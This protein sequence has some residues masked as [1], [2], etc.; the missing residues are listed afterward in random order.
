MDKTG[1]R[2]GG[3]D[4]TFSQVGDQ[5]VDANQTGGGEPRKA[6]RIVAQPWDKV[7]KHRSVVAPV[8]SNAN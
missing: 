7:T 2:R 5:V 8:R 3:F 1:R 6:K 4:G